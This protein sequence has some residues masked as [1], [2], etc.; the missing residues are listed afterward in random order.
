MYFYI[1]QNGDSPAREFFDDCQPSMRNKFE[2]SFEALVKM[3]K[4]YEFR[5][6]FTPLSGVGKPLWEFKEHDARIYCERIAF[7]NGSVQA[8]LLLG[9]TKDKAG[10]AREEPIRIKAALAIYQERLTE[11]FRR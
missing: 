5:E 10:K 9:W 8:F 2:G 6:R 11:G 4:A 7:G 3:G 1:R